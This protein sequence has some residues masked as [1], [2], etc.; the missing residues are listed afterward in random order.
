MKPATLSDSNEATMPAFIINRREIAGALGDIGV[1]LP[2]MAGLILVCGLSAFTVF[3]F[4][5]ATYLAAGLYFRLPVPVQPL[6]AMAAIAIAGGAGAEELAAG[7]IIM[8]VLLLF[9]SVTGLAS[10]LTR[11]F[12][13]WTVK[14]VQLAVGLMLIKASIPFINGG[15]SAVWKAATGTG[16]TGSAALLL[17][18]ASL[19][20]LLFFNQ[21]RKIPAALA[22]LT[23]GF[24]FSFFIAGP[25]I[26]GS[27]AI[28]GPELPSISIPGWE[29]FIAAFFLLVVPQVPVTF[30]NSVIATTDVAHSYFKKRAGR[31]TPKALCASLGIA[32]TAIGLLGGMPVCHGSGGM[33]AHYR[34]GARSGGAAVLMGVLLLSLALLFGDSAVYLILMLPLPI[35][36]A[37][38]IYVGIEHARLVLELLDNKLSLLAAVTIGVISLLWGNIAVGMVIGIG[39]SF[40]AGAFG[41]FREYLL[42]DEID[43]LQAIK[44]KVNK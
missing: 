41:M 6:K 11:L 5:G 15:G 29:S 12:S 4:T 27:L 39:I 19:T 10:Q 34:L 30:G 2:L 28:S 32:N 13:P 36:G 40:L 22:V 1:L 33:T 18:G 9:L 23:I 44:A 7:G 26:I 42:P 37:F 21:S 43:S 35:L 31:V 24:M 16:I 17:A 8:G 20:L 25:T 38:I 14:G 3:L